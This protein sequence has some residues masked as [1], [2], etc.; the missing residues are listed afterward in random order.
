MILE[1]AQYEGIYDRIRIT[2]S[3][4]GDLSFCEQP[5]HFVAIAIVDTALVGFAMYNLTH[6][7]VCVNVTD[8]IYIENLYVSPEFHQQGIGVALLR[9]VA[10]VAKNTNASRIEWWVSRHNPEARCFYEKIGAT[11]LSDWDIYK[12]DKK[13]IDQLLG[14]EP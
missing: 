11:A 6:H 2:E 12:C 4:L 7:N 1:L 14:Y 13:C 8:G 5:N 9:H 3:E 10:T